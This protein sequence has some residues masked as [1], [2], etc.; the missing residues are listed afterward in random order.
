MDNASPAVYLVSVPTAQERRSHLHKIGIPSSWLQNYCFTEDLRDAQ[1]SYID[2]I[3]NPVLSIRRY[4]R[5]LNKGEVGCA[6]SHMN[7]YREIVEKRLDCALI[8]EDDI[9]PLEKN[10]ISQK[11]KYLHNR[12]I[13]LNPINVSFICHLGVSRENFENIGKQKMINIRSLFTRTYNDE[14][15][16]YA[17]FS[18]LYSVWYTHAYFISYKAAYQILANET[19]IFLV[20]DDWKY[21]AKL[22][23]IEDI[24]FTS[25]LFDQ[26]NDFESLIDHTLGWK[27]E[28]QSSL[29]FLCRQLMELKLVIRAIA[30]KV[31]LNL[32]ILV[33][34]IY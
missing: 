26:N 31:M 21:R 16:L 33:P 30:R 8:L 19:K 23:Y 15:S 22:G 2:T 32:L 12:L 9:L 6:K 4:G 3:T 28:N 18:T 34:R 17:L 14:P 25:T 1:D 20:A 24:F 10:L 13:M 27:K 11:I 7:I 5:P 29:G